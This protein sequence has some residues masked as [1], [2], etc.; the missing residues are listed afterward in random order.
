MAVLEVRHRVQ[1]DEGARMTVSPPHVNGNGYAPI[2]NGSPGSTVFVCADKG[3]A[4]AMT[5]VGIPATYWYTE[6][7]KVRSFVEA[8]KTIVVHCGAKEKGIAFMATGIIGREFKP[9]AVGSVDLSVEVRFVDDPRDFGRWLPGEIDAE[10]FESE[11]DFVSLIS[12]LT[13]WRGDQAPMPGNHAQSNGTGHQA[14]ANTPAAAIDAEWAAFTDAE[15]G[16]IPAESVTM[17]PIEWLWPYRLAAGEMAML[18]GDGGLGKSS[19]LLAIAALVT[20]GGPWPDGSG[21]APV[22]SIIIVS[23]EDSRETT[24]KPRL[25][26]L[27]A[28]VSKIKFVTARLVIPAKNGTPPKVDPMTLQD[29]PYWREVIKRVPGCKMMIVDP[30]PSYLGRGVND[31]KNNE[32]RNVLEPFLEMVTRPSGVSLVGLAHLNKQADSKTPLHRI[33]GSIAYGALPRNVHF[34]LRDADK[35]GRLLFKQAK[36][37]N[38]PDDLP[39]IAYSLKTM[40]VP[41]PLGDIEASFPEFEPDTVQVDL[42]AAMGGTSRKRGPDPVKTTELAKF[43]VEFLAAKGPVHLGEIAEEAGK[44][45]LIGNATI[46]QGRPSWTGFTGLYR[47]IDDVPGLPAPDN[48]WTVVTSKDDPALR[49]MNGKARWQLRRPESAY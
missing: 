24:L 4:E 21:N 5:S 13:A 49:S 11:A 16:I 26:A 42:S 44:R 33:S 36:C 3:L 29:R 41:S 46:H 30:V 43:L 17:K 23:A 8:R 38:A 47:A 39:A 25:I 27:G 22:G 48:G 37:N 6:Q 31:A 15:L 9:Q 40:A 19:L 34:V 20:K 2:G 28:D 1:A 7:L 14:A 18:A 12:S 10:V 45:G 32:L 35:P